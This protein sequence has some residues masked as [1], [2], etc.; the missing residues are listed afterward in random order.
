MGDP[1]ENVGHAVNDEPG[2]ATSEATSASGEDIAVTLEQLIRVHFSQSFRSGLKPA[3]WH[4]LRYFATAEPE[5]RTVTAFA[6]HRAS[7]MGTASTTI[8]TLVRK[9]YLARDYGRGVPRN[10][11][12]HI[13]DAGR[14]LLQQDPIQNLVNAINRLGDSERANLDTALHRLVADMVDSPDRETA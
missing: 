6:R 3:Q 7:T 4:A 5:D 11:G 14:E 10:R 9:G 2:V 8:S 13:T 12:L 1:Q